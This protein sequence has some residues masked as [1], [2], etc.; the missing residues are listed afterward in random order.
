[1]GGLSED[2]QWKA[3]C[4]S[5]KA[6]MPMWRYRVITMLRLAQKQQRIAVTNVFSDN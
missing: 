2:N 6:V 3:I 4:F 1:M 5:K